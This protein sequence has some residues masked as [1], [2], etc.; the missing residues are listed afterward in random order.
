MFL[1]LWNCAMITLI[2]STSTHVPTV[3]SFDFLAK[4]VDAL[5]PIINE[6]S[7]ADG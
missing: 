3:W 4:S 1:R 6:A 5:L 7:G 2:R